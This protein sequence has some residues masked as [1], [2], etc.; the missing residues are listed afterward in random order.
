MN[1]YERRRRNERAAKAPTITSIVELAL[2][3]ADDFMTVPAI[4]DRTGLSIN[5]VTAS[6]V[7]L[8]NFGAI[9]F[10]SQPSPGGTAPVTY[11]F[12]TPGSDRRQKKLEERVR[13]EEGTRSPR[14]SRK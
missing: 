7:H 5:R 12:A 11:W 1:I 9:E 10:V 14:R 6:L 2:R 13:E 3:E 8:R 4:M